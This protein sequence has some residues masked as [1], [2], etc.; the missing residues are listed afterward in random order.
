MTEIDLIFALFFF[1]G[2]Q[3]LQ[4]CLIFCREKILKIRKVKKT[5][6][7]KVYFISGHKNM[8]TCILPDDVCSVLK[9]NKEM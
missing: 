2:G 4:I 6:K 5:L 8:W 3:R 9:I 7:F 1:A